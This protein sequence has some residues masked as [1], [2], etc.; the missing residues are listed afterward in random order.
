MKQTAPTAVSPAA[1]S[2]GEP[3]AFIL[4]SAATLC[5]LLTAHLSAAQQ[6]AAQETPQQQLQRLALA[7][8]QAQAQVAASQH[9]PIKPE[10]FPRLQR[11]M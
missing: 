10:T 6:S 1:A 2:P 11:I 5:F 3:A 4:R 7:V 9:S 8:E